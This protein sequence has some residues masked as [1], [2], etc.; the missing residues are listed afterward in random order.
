MDSNLKI[1]KSNYE[2]LVI[3]SNIDVTLGV[4]SVNN[5]HLDKQNWFK[6]EKLKKEIQTNWPKG[7]ICLSDDDFLEVLIKYTDIIDSTQT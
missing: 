1:E 3:H 4:A 7:T 5:I 2:M 6:L